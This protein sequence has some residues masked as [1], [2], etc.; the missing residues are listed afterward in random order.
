MQEQDGWSLV[1]LPAAP[2]M[3]VKTFL[4]SAEMKRK[5][6]GEAATGVCGSDCPAGVQ[7]AV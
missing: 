3:E 2:L 7:G 1:S 6:R 4:M 5:P